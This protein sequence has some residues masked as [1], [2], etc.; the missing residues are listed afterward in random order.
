MLEVVLGGI[1]GE[2]TRMRRRSLSSY[3]V[4]LDVSDKRAN[5]EMSISEEHL[6]RSSFQNEHLAS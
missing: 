2:R 4:Y 1:A 5:A 3:I 6:L